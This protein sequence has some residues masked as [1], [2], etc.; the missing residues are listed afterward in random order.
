V[1][2]PSGATPDKIIKPDI[3]PLQPTAR[4]VTLYLL[5]ANHKGAKLM[6][7]VNANVNG[8]WLAVYRD[9]RE[10]YTEMVDKPG[11]HGELFERCDV[12]SAVEWVMK[13]YTDILEVSISPFE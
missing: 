6:F 2:G 4:N 10:F 11:E 13:N 8:V 1:S 7:T 12:S 3:L 9:E 5:R